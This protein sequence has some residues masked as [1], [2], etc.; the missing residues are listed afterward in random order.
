MQTTGSLKD[1]VRDLASGKLIVSFLVD[2]PTIVL[3]DD[4]LDITAEKHRKK[5]SLNANGLLWQCLGKI[6]ASINADKW[7]VYLMMLKRYGAFTYVCVPPSA[8]DMLK[9]Q[10]RECEEI[11]EININ[12]RQ[13]VQMLCYYGSSTYDAK[14]F[15]VLL[16]GVIGEMKEMGIETPDEE[17]VKEYLKQWEKQNGKG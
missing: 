7:D 16:D 12:G 2:A 17:R 9:R 8:V 4:I 6:A 3:P 13:A 11:G 15:S 10:W 5:R 1:V 14:Q